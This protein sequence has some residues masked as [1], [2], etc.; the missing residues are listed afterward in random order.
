MSQADE[1]KDEEIMKEALAIIGVAS[2][3]EAEPFVNID[4]LDYKGVAMTA[5]LGMA[6]SNKGD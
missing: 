6:I 5:D 2:D 3:S 4:L 1:Q